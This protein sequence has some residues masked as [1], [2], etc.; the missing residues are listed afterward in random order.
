[1]KGKELELSQS[2]LANNYYRLSLQQQF[3]GFHQKI[4]GRLT[5]EELDLTDLGFETGTRDTTSTAKMIILEKN[6][7][8]QFPHFH[9]LFHPTIHFRPECTA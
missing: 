8:T 9:P 5:E 1:L 6:E 7:I 2:D 3:C 4:R